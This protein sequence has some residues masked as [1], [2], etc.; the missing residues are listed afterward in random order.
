MKK[1]L[2][3][4]ALPES[5]LNFR[6]HLIQRLVNE[7][8]SVVAMASQNDEDVKSRLADLGANYDWYHVERNNLNPF[9]DIATLIDLIKAFR[10]HQPDVILSYT[11]KPVIWG[12]IAALFVPR[13]KFFALIT[14]LGFAFQGKSLARKSL[15]ILVVSLYRVALARSTKAIFQNPDNL[16][17]FVKR[18]IVSQDKC[19]LVNGSGVD[20]QAF[21]YVEPPADGCTFLMIGRLLGEKGFREYFS[22][23]SQVKT[24]YPEANFK[25]LGPLD[26][27]P[28]G[29][30]LAEV[31]RWEKEGAIEYLGEN[32]NV[33]PF[34]ES[35]HVYVL[36]SY[37]E[38][39]PRTVLEAMAVGRPII[40]TDVSGCRETV[41]P[42]YNGYL[43]PSMDSSALAECLVRFIDSRDSWAEMGRHS[44]E[45]VEKKFDV[46]SVNK[47]ILALL[48]C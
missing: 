24:K 12:A 40:T 39:M 5:L 1:I 3:V 46:H 10:K 45:L 37:H 35:C 36:P 7:G 48:N 30:D 11:I 27:S 26:P 33:R 34:L 31:E 29:L 15:N 43:V 25:V 2:V 20:L 9:S 19:A 6:G 47:E 44:R 4:G 14:G 38:G 28:D 22:A 8:H 17:E 21:K 16:G 32:S 18:K 42:G 41:S 23:A 13:A